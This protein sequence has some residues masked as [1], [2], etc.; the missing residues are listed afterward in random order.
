MYV[1]ESG[2]GGGG[3]QEHAAAALSGFHVWRC[4]VFGICRRDATVVCLR[5]FHCR[6]ALLNNRLPSTVAANTIRRRSLLFRRHL[7]LHD[8]V[9]HVQTLDRRALSLLGDV[10]RGRL[11]RRRVTM[12]SAHSH[13]TTLATATQRVLLA[14]TEQYL[15]LPLQAEQ[16]RVA[17]LLRWRGARRGRC[18]GHP[19]EGGANV[20]GDAGGGLRLRERVEFVERASFG[21]VATQPSLVLGVVCLRVAAMRVVTQRA[22]D[23][24]LSDDVFCG[25]QE[26]GSFW[27]FAGR[28]T[29]AAL[30]WTHERAPDV[31]LALELRK[32][33]DADVTEVVA[34]RHLLA[35]DRD[36]LA[37]ARPPPLAHVH[38]IRKRAVHRRDDVIVQTHCNG[39]HTGKTCAGNVQVRDVTGKKTSED[40]RDMQWRQHASERQVHGDWRGVW[41]WTSRGKEEE[42]IR[43]W[44]LATERVCCCWTVTKLE[45][46]VDGLQRGGVRYVNV[47]NCTLI[48]Q[49]SRVQYMNYN[50]TLWSP[51]HASRPSMS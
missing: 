40:N 32:V 5:V 10:M 14:H 3:S 26:R 34:D 51:M 25:G 38:S 13:P 41:V 42:V 12:R 2:V 20:G 6:F 7:V 45:Q 27:E 44:V 23:A 1:C 19:G 33:V 4:L 21:R 48:V 46:E 15:L 24:L 35:V 30:D 22:H 36:H 17:T 37:H 11:Q 39:S 49:Y 8:D 29:A 18:A 50:S 9:I 31:L 16:R 47:L 43:T 28:V